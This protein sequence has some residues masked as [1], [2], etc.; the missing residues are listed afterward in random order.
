MKLQDLLEVLP[1]Y[2]ADGDISEIDINTVKADSRQV[3][4]GSLFVCI[5]GY[6]VDGHDFVEEAVKQG[7]SAILSEKEV[8]ASVPV[9]QVADTS[10][11]MAKMAV[12]FYGYPT[13]QI[14]LIGVTGTNGKTTVTYLLESIFKE[15]E[16]KTG[17]IG[18]IQ[19]KIGDNAYPV[20][21]T[22]PDALSLQKTFQDMVDEHVETAI[23]EVS[24]HALDMGR[25]HGC[26]F[27]IAVFT[28]L[29]QDH[30]DYHH[31]MN[32]YLHAKSLLFAQLGNTYN[33]N[34]KK[35]AVINEDDAHSGFL[36]KSTAQHIL[37]YG[38]GVDAQVRAD[39]IYLDVMKTTFTLNTPAGSVL[40]NSSLIG[41]F[42][43]YN[44]LAASAAAISA[45]IPL[46]VIKK[47][48]DQMSGVSGRFEPVD[49]D[50][51]YA[52]IVD[53]AHTPDSLENVLQTIRGFTKHNVYAVVGCGGDRDKAKR[54]VMAS[55]ALKYADQAIFTS[56]NPRTEAP[57]AILDDMAAGCQTD[58]YVI[59][60]NRREAISRA[61][62]QGETGD[63]IL[64]AGKGHET[65][66]EIHHTQ[67]HFDDR[68]VAQEAIQSRNLKEDQ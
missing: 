32:D 64:I 21:N 13:Q 68:E 20:D 46:A 23:M 3:T 39:N 19:K 54:P 6:T 44:M 58:N 52:V 25:V 48:L 40:I 59:I 60:E 7:A 41:Q 8:T 26:D 9:I 15:F 43:V 18:T 28:N 17:V 5:T 49:G 53:Y 29:S 22:T 35:F 34:Q 31:D 57:L 47:A 12:R 63:I 10:R 62:N 38:C 42:N 55:I 24:S 51:D 50:Q 66:Q 30:L 11:I 2:Y 56:D 65:Y 37:T 61:V 14:P 4:E 27:D 67:H 36:K 45:G 1:F 33:S 16:K